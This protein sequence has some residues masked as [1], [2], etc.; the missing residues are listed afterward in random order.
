M[1]A[2]SIHRRRLLAGAGC[3]LLASPAFALGGAALPVPRSG[4]LS[5]RALRNGSE[6]GTHSLQFTT[7]GDGV[8]VAIAVDYVVKLGPIPVFRYALRATEQWRNGVLVSVRAKTND[9]GKDA[10]MNA[11]RDGDAM[12][13]DGSK[14]GRYR[15]PPGAIASSHW[16]P[17]EVDAP[18]INLQNG[19]LLRFAVARPGEEVIRSAAETPIP[20]TRFALSGPTSMDLWYD[21]GG[22]WAGLR[23]KAEDGSLILYQR[24]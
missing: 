3:T 1:L 22:I 19:E 8:T 13:V 18:M 23:A 12:N 6:L 2:S 20:A 5:F 15:A 16:N 10:F 9:D 24:N 4:A 7:A 14:S 17:A 21:M 11:D